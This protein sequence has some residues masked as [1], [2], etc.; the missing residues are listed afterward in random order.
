MNLEFASIKDLKPGM[1]NLNMI[2][3]VL[4]MGRSNITKEGHEVRTCKVADKSGAVNMSMWDEPGQL[5]QSGDI[6]RLTKGYTA[7][8]KA[9]LTLYMGKGGEL[10][11]IGEF[12]LVFSETP[13]MSE[14]N[15]DYIQNQQSILEA[16]RSQ[17][18][19][20]QQPNQNSAITN[21]ET[22]AQNVGNGSSQRNNNN[23]NN[24]NNNGRN[25]SSLA[26]TFSTGNAGNTRPAIQ[27]NGLNNN[28][29][30]NNSRR[31]ARR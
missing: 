13:F 23:G 15:L 7:M 14:P 24:N 3:I 10:L 19:T 26:S 27:T 4:D 31:Q 28:S 21:A 22:R 29:S 1:K 25:Q 6:C 18:P 20:N 30:N 5:L 2:F 9:C 16:N 17:S 11:K 12:C 8:W